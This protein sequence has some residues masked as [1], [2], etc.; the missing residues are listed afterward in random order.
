MSEFVPVVFEVI[1]AQIIVMM[2]GQIAEEASNYILSCSTQM[3]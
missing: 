2:P 3:I 1:K